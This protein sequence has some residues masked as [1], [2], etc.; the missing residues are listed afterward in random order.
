MW[1]NWIVEWLGSALQQGGLV[2]NITIKVHE[3]EDSYF[4]FLELLEKSMQIHGIVAWLVKQKLNRPKVEYHT[5]LILA[6]GTSNKGGVVSNEKVYRLYHIKSAQRRDY[7][8]PHM[9]EDSAE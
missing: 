1:D 4:G 2:S 8:E 6:Q 3:I 9:L 5:W 7:R